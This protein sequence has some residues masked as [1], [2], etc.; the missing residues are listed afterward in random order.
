MQNLKEELDNFN[1]FKI[2]ISN[3]ALKYFGKE[4]HHLFM[5]HEDKVGLFNASFQF[6][7][8]LVEI[9]N[10]ENPDDL[11]ESRILTIH[12]NTKNIE[13]KYTQFICAHVEENYDYRLVARVG[14]T[15]I[16]EF[17]RMIKEKYDDIPP[18]EVIDE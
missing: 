8:R 6:L 15:F 11:D 14:G 10:F 16:S 7:K 3:E 9:Y 5:R 2:N 18:L 4:L 1:K 12:Q 17:R 13:K